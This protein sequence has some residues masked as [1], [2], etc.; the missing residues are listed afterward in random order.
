MAAH[1][2]CATIILGTLLAMAGFQSQLLASSTIFG[3]AQADLRDFQRAANMYRSDYGHYPC[4]DSQSTWFEKLLSAGILLPGFNKT[5]RD[6]SLPIDR[7]G[8]PY[9]YIL[10]EGSNTD[11]SGEMMPILRWVGLNGIDD[12]GKGDDIDLRYGVNYGYYHKAGYPDALGAIFV[13]VLLTTALMRLFLRVVTPWKIRF[14]IILTWLSAWVT[15]VGIIGNSPFCH[16]CNGIYENLAGIGVMGFLFGLIGCFATGLGTWIMR[17]RRADL[18]RANL[19]VDCKYDLRG[20]ESSICPECGHDR[21]D[22]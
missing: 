10:P 19:C 22:G 16:G 2:R 9:I 8:V 6:G 21:T 14:S 15:T 17:E 5:T 18:R 13:G 12:Q 20:S 3:R 1:S 7:N 4:T 11:P